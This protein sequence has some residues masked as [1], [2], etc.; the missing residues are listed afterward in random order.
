MVFSIIGWILLGALA[1]WV[2]SLIMHTDA[3]QGPGMNIAV[4][5]V[6]ALIGGFL[7]RLLGGPGVAG[8]TFTS[9]VI[10]TLGAIILL[11]VLKPLR[12]H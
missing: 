5:I 9:F 2:A 7:S 4:G 11:A 1:G 6:G 8:L 10:A 12:H 3:E